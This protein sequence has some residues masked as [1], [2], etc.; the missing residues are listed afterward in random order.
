MDDLITLKTQAFDD[1]VAD[2]TD[3]F[4]KNF[5]EQIDDLYKVVHLH[6]RQ[7]LVW[8]AISKKEQFTAAIQN[9]R[10]MFVS[11]LVETRTTIVDALNAEREGFGEYI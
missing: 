3:N 4:I 6:E 10:V 7:A 11:S 1:L 2:L 8:K 9:L 5:W